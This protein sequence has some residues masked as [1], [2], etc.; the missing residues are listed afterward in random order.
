M[1][2][3]LYRP[4]IAC[5]IFLV[6]EV[7]AN[8]VV[9]TS[10]SVAGFIIGQRLS[11][12]LSPDI[13]SRQWEDDE[14]GSRYEFVRARVKGAYFNLEVYDKKVWRITVEKQGMRTQDGIGV[15]D[16]LEKLIR[17]DRTL[18]PYVGSGPS[19]VLISHK[20]CG[21]SFVTNVELPDKIPE[22]L[23]LDI[24]AQRWHAKQIKK[25]IVVGCS[26][27]QKDES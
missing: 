26:L 22:K 5:C 19:L 4:A 14:N 3:S 10:S 11:P 21:L 20:S 13:I 1:L 18:E 2:K 25:I 8:N 15:D 12:K 24:V 17:V 23:T 7:F 27:M 6:S 9:I 16:S